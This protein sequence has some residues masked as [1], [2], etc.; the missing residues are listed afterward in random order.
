ME[1]NSID[2][3]FIDDLIKLID[4]FVDCQKGKITV[5]SELKKVETFFRNKWQKK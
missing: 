4:T 2:K 1:K 5:I 3:E